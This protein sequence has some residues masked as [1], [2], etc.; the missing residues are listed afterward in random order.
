MSILDTF[1]HFAKPNTL[2]LPLPNHRKRGVT[3]RTSYLRVQISLVIGA[4]YYSFWGIAL[5]VLDPMGWNPKVFRLT[6]GM[7]SLLGLILIP[8]SKKF[9]VH[10]GTYLN[11]LLGSSALYNFAW[12][13]QNSYLP[14]YFAIYSIASVAICLAAITFRAS[15][16]LALLQGGLVLLVPILKT[17]ADPMSELMT[18][19]LAST[20]GLAPALQY[21]AEKSIRTLANTSREFR[22]IIDSLQE[23]LLLQDAK[24]RVLFFNRFAADILLLKAS[25]LHSVSVLDSRSEAIDESGGTIPEGSHPVALAQRTG[26]VRRNHVIGIRLS[27]GELRWL[28]TTAIPVPSEAFAA[29]A[30]MRSKPNAKDPEAGILCAFE[31]ITSER[32]REALLTE[33]RAKVLESARLSS[34]GESAAGLAHEINNPLAILKLR[35]D[36]IRERRPSPEVIKDLDFATK[37][38]DRIAGLVKSLRLLSRDGSRDPLEQVQLVTIVDDCFQLYE[39]RLKKAQIQLKCTLNRDLRVLCRASEVGQ[40]LSNLIHNSIDAIQDRNEQQGSP[41]SPDWIVIRTQP[42]PEGAVV[43]A[44]EDSGPGIPAE[45]QRKIMEPFF[46]TKPPGKGVG[47]GLSISRSLMASQGGSL[48]YVASGVGASFRLV[49]RAAPAHKSAA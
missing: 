16:I 30:R 24:G 44:I 26:Q 12:L 17:I 25:H 15:L 5:D 18:F 29:L 48:E 27:T 34:L 36:S 22:T 2:Q 39:S 43:L 3:L 33:S 20:L 19:G 4:L 28:R 23:G 32:E 45:L 42:G 37:A 35:L 46:T 13:H 47:I 41:A 9:R 7:A 31:D 14:F 8:R 49:F 40:V 6:I 1:A 10:A 38:A 11:V 21:S